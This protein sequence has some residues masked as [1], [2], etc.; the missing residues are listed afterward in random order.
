M[1]LRTRL[2]IIAG[3]G[4]AGVAMAPPFT[5]HAPPAGAKAAKC[6]AATRGTV[7]KYGKTVS[8]GLHGFPG[9]PGRSEN[10]SF[11]GAGTIASACLP[12]WRAYHVGRL[13]QVGGD[14]T[15]GE[16]AAAKYFYDYG[17]F[18][19]DGEDLSRR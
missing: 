2:A 14:W 4:A 18:W 5:V 8:P 10:V 6:H 17:G 16:W 3:A 19:L 1:R 12:H 15:T 13:Y 7:T 9:F 11:V